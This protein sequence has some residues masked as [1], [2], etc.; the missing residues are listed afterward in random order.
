MLKKYGQEE[1][2]RLKRLKGGG[3]KFT[4]EELDDL[5]KELKL[6]L[7]NLYV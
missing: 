3:K 5:T 1:I 4:I 6:K 2:D 7:K